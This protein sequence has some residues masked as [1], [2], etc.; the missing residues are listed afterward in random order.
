MS[1]LVPLD[2][3]EVAEK[4]LVQVRNL[5]DHF[6]KDNVSLVLFRVCELFDLPHQYPPQMSMSYEEYLEYE[7]K[8]CKTICQTYLSEIEGML[9]T[10]GLQVRSEVAVGNV[11]DELINY[12]SGNPVDLVIMSTHGRTGISR[13]AFGGIAEKVLKGNP[14]PILLV[15]SVP[16]G[17]H[18]KK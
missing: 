12:I 13:W 7:T 9:K 5:T 18:D 11:A 16:V 14:V 17:E 8:R 3:S 1:V 6:G 15:R 4:V 2:G 10:E